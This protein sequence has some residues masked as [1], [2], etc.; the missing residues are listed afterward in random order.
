MTLKIISHVFGPLENNTYLLWDSQTSQAVIIDPALESEGLLDVIKKNGLKPVAIWITH[1]H[2]D[3]IGGVSAISQAF[4]PALP[5]YLHPD[6]LDLWRQGGGSLN[7][8]LDLDV[9]EPPS[10]FFTDGQKILLGEHEVQ[11]R[12]TP[13]HTRGHV[14]LYAPDAR[15]AFVGDLIFYHGVG[16]T[17]LPGGSHADLLN[18]I[19]TQ[20]FTLPENTRLLSGHGPETTVEEEQISNPFI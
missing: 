11:V 18:S 17:D 14:I 4:Q 8:G 7:F 3:H 19:H 6:D 10:Q 2:F 5:I 16:R 12:H 13:G 9:S 20:V 15:A 1:A